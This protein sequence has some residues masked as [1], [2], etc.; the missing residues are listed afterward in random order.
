MLHE[1]DVIRR[2]KMNFMNSG[3][4]FFHCTVPSIFASGKQNIPTRNTG[5]YTK[6]Q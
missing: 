4:S 2:L 1:Y 5:Q 3:Y 6:N